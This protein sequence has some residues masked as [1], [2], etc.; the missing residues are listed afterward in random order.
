MHED[1]SAGKRVGRAAVGHPV[2]V[3]SGTLF[4]ELE[5]VEI[6]GRVPL[7]FG[8][9][10]SSALA[11]V[12]RGM[13]GPGWASPFEMYLI[14]D[15]DGYRMLDA[16]G[17]TEIHFDDPDEMVSAGDVVRDLGAFCELRM[18]DDALV[19]TRWDPDSEEIARFVFRP[20][21]D[22]QRWLLAAIEDAEG[23]GL[24]IR[25]DDA[26]H[27]TAIKQR[28]EQRGLRLVYDEQDRVIEVYLTVP[29]RGW[30]EVGRQGPDDE[31]IALRYSYDQFGFLSEV[32][33][34][35]Q[36]RCRYRYTPAGYMT[37]E[38]NIG[39]TVY[40]F[41]YD[42]Q[43]RCVETTGEDDFGLTQLEHQPVARVTIVTD[44]FGHQ[45]TFQY[46][47]NGQVTAEISPLG[48]VKTSEFD[49]HGRL[50]MEV[51][52]AGAVTSHE[53]DARGDRVKTTSPNGGVT[54]YA[55]NF[56]HQLTTVVDVEENPWVRVFDEAG[57][58]ESVANPLGQRLSYRYDVNGDLIQMENPEGGACTFGWDHLGNLC[59]VTDWLGN[60]TRHEYDR[61]GHLIAT[62]DPEGC[63]TEAKLDTLGRIRELR[64]PD[65]SRRSYTWDAFDQPTRHTDEKGA[66]TAWRYEACGLLAEVTQPHGGKVRFLWS[67]IPG[68]LTGVINARGER[69]QFSY[70]S[71]GDVIRETDFAGRTLSYEHDADGHVSA[72]EDTAGQRTEISHNVDGTV[73]I[74]SHDDGTET[75]FD[76]CKRGLLVSADNGDC[77]VERRFDAAGRLIYEKQ[78]EHEVSS[79]FDTLGNRVLRDSLGL[80]TRFTWDANGRL[81]GQESNG[82][83]PIHFEYNAIQQE[84]A[85]F[86]N[87]GV[88][89]DL[90]YDGRGRRIGQQVTTDS[91]AGSGRASVGEHLIHRKYS[92]DAASNLTAMV[93]QRWGTTR[94]TYDMVGRVLGAQL[95]GNLA[96]RFQYDDSGN[97]TAFSRQSGDVSTDTESADW[98]QCEVA[99]GDLLVRR[100]KDT[101]TY[102][103]AGRLSS[104]TTELGETS[105][106]WNRAGQLSGVTLP[107]GDCWEYGYDA[108][109]R[110]V[111]KAGPEEVITFIWDGDVVLHEIRQ[112]RDDLD[113]QQI[114][115]YSFDPYGFD[116]IEKIEGKE[117]YLFVNDVAGNPREMV[118]ADGQV[119]WSARFSA[120][121]ELLEADAS[122]QSCDIRFQGQWHDAE[123]GLSYN[124]HRY[125]DPGAGRFV[126]P[127]PVGLWGGLNDYG[128]APNTTGWAD[129]YGLTGKCPKGE[130]GE[131]EDLA[132]SYR[133]ATKK[134]RPSTVAVLKTK[135]GDSTPGRS[136]FEKGKVHP[137]VQA[138]LDEVPVDQRKP[139]HGRCAEID[140]V[141]TAMLDGKDVR[142]STIRTAKVRSPR[143]GKAAEHGT[144]HTPCPTCTSVLG[145]L[146]VNYD[147]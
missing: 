141:N 71:G 3:A 103:D 14:Q 63:R 85:R 134:Q 21:G 138:A 146:G 61:E 53:Y 98:Q 31:H 20:A 36:Q 59:S 8:R 114:A 60:L 62:E 122:Q 113:A 120:W 7:V 49:E 22:G 126:S 50:V 70:N 33:D 5:D 72:I 23:Q 65:G 111:R 1:K 135:S 32:T 115:H 89:I 51:S 125:Y 34:A 75:T 109:G 68:Q 69:Y 140:A 117:Q 90:R 128:Y 81:T 129:P 88:R 52:A 96:E 27:V 116:P 26:H 104:R 93:D 145:K 94:F 91:S 13:F 112:R 121:G 16:D 77:A 107:D 4:H 100:G 45:T 124:R 30:D 83:S 46:N 58:V 42:G 74:I 11:G 6:P 25:R 18:E 95:P 144:P 123:T 131:V 56:R 19:T 44:S 142:G 35:L 24:D 133:N 43:G 99:S 38:K 80:Q 29:A 48:N 40:T 143:S 2:D 12:G 67:S 139:F 82:L 15:L 127:D 17:E 39:G 87:D 9:R 78:G 28:R 57:R 132:D 84:C 54:R 110:R 137:K 76:Y 101:Y 119:V 108:F 118:S 64:M 55:Y 79:E 73:S 41:T 86:V 97:I 136:G 66:E 147:G 47:D 37:R 105:Y 130:R 10:Y 92:Y 102:D 106:C